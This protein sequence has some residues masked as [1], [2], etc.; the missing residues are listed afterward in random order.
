MGFVSILQT[1][2]KTIAETKKIPRWQY[3]EL[4][5]QK[6]LYSPDYLRELLKQAKEL[7]DKEAMRIIYRYIKRHGAENIG[8]YGKIVREIIDYLT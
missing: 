4:N 7:D 8:R 6:L 3:T 5:T 2:F 1:V